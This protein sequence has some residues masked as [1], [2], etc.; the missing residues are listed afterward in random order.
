MN[1]EFN[2]AEDL[3]SFKILGKNNKPNYIPQSRS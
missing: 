1:W 3:A 2:K